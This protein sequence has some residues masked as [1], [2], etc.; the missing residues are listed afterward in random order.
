MLSGRASIS[1]KILHG[2]QEMEGCFSLD[3]KSGPPLGSEDSKEFPGID[4]TREYPHR[5]SQSSF[6]GPNFDVEDTGAMNSN[7]RSTCLIFKSQD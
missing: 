5:S 6:K 4:S 3:S 1:D 2:L 7:C